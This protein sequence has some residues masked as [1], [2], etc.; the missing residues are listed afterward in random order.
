MTDWNQQQ[1]DPQNSGL[2]RDLEGP[3]RVTEAWTVDLVGPPGSPVCDRDTVYVG[4]TRGNC[5]ALEAETGRRRWVFET[6]TATDTTPVV[7]RDRLYVGAD[8]GTIVALEPATGEVAWEVELL[9]DLESDLTLSDGRLYAGHAT[10]LSALDAETGAVLWTHETDAAV[11]GTPAV[12]DGRDVDRSR[13]TGSPL[14][15]PDE[16]ALLETD[17]LS[18]PD[19]RWAEERVFAGTADGTVFALEAE[20]SDQLWT[21]PT[22]GAVTTGPTVAADRV[23]VADRA[24]TMLALDAATGQTWFTYEIQGGFTTSPTVLAAAETTF[25]GATDGYCHVTDT[26]VGRRKLRGWLFSRKGVEL[27]GPVR[28]AP[29]VIGDVCCVGDASGSLYGIAVADAEPIWHV[30]LA[31]AVSDTP[32]VAAG[33]LFVGSDDDRLTCLEWETAAPNR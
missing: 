7:T 6:T 3:S 1:G 2:Q 33:R 18:G 32:A 11:T 5:Y 10:G 4:T 24:G 12:A 23:Y 30:A 29:V 14:S 22:G 15:E 16:T 17:Q 28:S 26:T 31:D 25:V 20:T 8:D 21:A 9:A 27:D 19:R 13:S